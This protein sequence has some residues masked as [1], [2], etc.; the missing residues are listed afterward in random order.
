MYDKYIWE[1]PTFYCLLKYWH[2]T[3]HKGNKYSICIKMWQ[4][5]RNV[6]FLHG[7]QII[8]NMF[9]RNTQYALYLLALV[10]FSFIAI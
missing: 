10:S 8:I 6:I 1:K 2:E 3:V 4:F 5:H 7:P 9:P